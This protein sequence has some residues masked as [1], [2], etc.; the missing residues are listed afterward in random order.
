MS[1]GELD[2]R[3]TIQRY[4]TTTNDFNE[5][6]KAWSDLTTIWAMRHDMS[7]AEKFSAGQV[8]A[9]LATRFKVRSSSTTRGVTANDRI[10]Y[11]G[12]L[13]DITGVKET[14]EGRKRYLWIEAVRQAD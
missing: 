4:T 5:E 6:V 8:N 2:R 13:F 14:T 1:A 7:S 10:S 9:T 11:D 3:I 12:G